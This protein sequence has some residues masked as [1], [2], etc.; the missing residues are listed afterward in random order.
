MPW[1]LCRLQGKQ[2]GRV[3][4]GPFFC[5]AF[6]LT[7][8]IPGIARLPELRFT[9]I[10]LI[11][12]PNSGLTSADDE[13]S[14][15][16]GLASGSRQVVD[17][18]PSYVGVR[19]ALAAGTLDAIHFAGH[20]AFPDQSNP[21]KAEIELDDGQSLRPTDI[22]GKTVNLGLATPVVF[23]NACQAGRQSRGL[24]GVGGWAGALLRAGA[25]AF[26][27]AHWEVADDLACRFATTFYDRLLGGATI[28]GAAREAR[29]GIRDG[30]DP[31]WLAYTVF[32][33]PGAKVVRT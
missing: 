12:P 23:L 18:R 9:N 4:E 32:A 27:G 24:T 8:W 26:V 31:T 19:Q 5:E 10:G 33:D 20:G 16:H 7:R 11:V 22:S 3:E 28:A 17:V 15:V 29:L 25:S 30:G 21:A 14:M 2:D 13:A 1:E 6:E